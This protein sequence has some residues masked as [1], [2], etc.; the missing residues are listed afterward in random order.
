IFQSLKA[1]GTL[2]QRKKEG[3]HGTCQGGLGLVLGDDT[4]IAHQRIAWA[5]STWEGVQDFLWG[6]SSHLALSPRHEI[7]ARVIL[8]GRNQCLE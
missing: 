6:R 1:S 8:Q 2:P 3:K 4:I 5:T 7:R